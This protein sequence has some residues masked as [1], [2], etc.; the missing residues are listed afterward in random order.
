MEKQTQ[1]PP[2]IDMECQLYGAGRK[3]IFS[4][5]S[6]YYSFYFAMQEIMDLMAI[7]ETTKLEKIEF[8]GRITERDSGTVT[9]VIKHYG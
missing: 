5:H 2:K 9:A 1:R 4:A 3:I 6:S 8:I 7:W